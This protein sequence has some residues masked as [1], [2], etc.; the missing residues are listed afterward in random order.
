MDGRGDLEKYTLTSEKIRLNISHSKD[1][2]KYEFCFTP[3]MAGN[4]SG[5]IYFYSE[6]TMVEIGSWVE[7][8]VAGQTIMERVSLITGNA[9]RNQNS[10]N[11]GLGVIF[12]LLIIVLILVIR[13]IVRNSAF[14][15]KHSQI[16]YSA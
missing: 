5:I 1:D 14:K 10:L 3:G 13:N 2:E 8:H 11:V 12:I 6:K 4:F 16:D 15:H 7:I 9:I